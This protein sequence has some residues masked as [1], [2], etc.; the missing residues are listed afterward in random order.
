MSCFL[1]DVNPKSKIQNPKSRVGL[2]RGGQSSLEV[3]VA[4]IGAIVLLFGSLKVFE[5][6]NERLI[7]RQIAYDEGQPETRV[8]GRVDAG[9][10]TDGQLVLWEEPSQPLR[11]FDE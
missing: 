11:I 6:I 8:G 2:S 1:S 5:W 10:R 4:L 3:T 7:S 9:S